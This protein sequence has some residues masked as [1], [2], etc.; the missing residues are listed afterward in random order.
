[1]CA[2]VFISHFR[3]ELL[4]AAPLVAMAMGR[5][6]RMAY[7]DDS[8]VQHPELL[9]RDRKLFMQVLGAFALCTILLFVDVPPLYKVAAAVTFR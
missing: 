8:L 7:S 3:L 6:M 4:L 1:M 9:Y 5:Y 2:G